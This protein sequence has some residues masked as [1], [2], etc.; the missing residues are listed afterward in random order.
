MIYALVLFGALTGNV[1]GVVLYD[2][3][4]SCVLAAK[5]YEGADH[6]KQTKCVRAHRGEQ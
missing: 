4:E 3:L 5:G 6:I 1:V 2:S